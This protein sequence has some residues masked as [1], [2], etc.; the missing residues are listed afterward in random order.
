MIVTAVNNYKVLVK[1]DKTKA[2][3]KT[4]HMLTKSCIIITDDTELERERNIEFSKSCTGT[5]VQI[6]S[7]AFQGAAK[8]EGSKIGDKVLFPRDEGIIVVEHHEDGTVDQY[9]IMSDTQIL[10]SVVLQDCELDEL[11][12]KE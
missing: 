12:T 10:A 3:K 7:T 6:G 9:R 2:I 1:V 5:L 8:G 4:E 11:A